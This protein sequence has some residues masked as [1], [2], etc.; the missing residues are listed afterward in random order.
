M[1]VNSRIHN[2][3]GVVK[4]SHVD[5]SLNANPIKPLGLKFTFTGTS[6]SDLMNL[7]KGYMIVRQK[8]IPTILTQGLAV[9]LS[10]KAKIPVLKNST[11]NI[12]ESFVKSEGS[13]VKLGN[14]FQIIP[15]TT[16]YI[17]T[18][19]LL[20]PEAN[21][22]SSL[23]QDYFN[24]SE[25]LLRSQKYKGLTYVG[26]NTNNPKVFD[27]ITLESNSPTTTIS[28]LTYVPKGTELI[29]DGVKSYSAK[30]GDAASSWKHADPINGDIEDISTSVQDTQVYKSFVKVRGEFNS[31]IGS[32]EN[33]TFGN[34]YNIMEKNY[35]VNSM[36]EYFKLRYN[37]KSS[38]SPISDRLEWSNSDV[39]P[40]LYRGDCYISTYTH[41]MMW[42]F[43]D[44]ELP[45]NTK[46]ID[47]YT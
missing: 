46:I 37:D 27:F 45:T 36:S 25:F 41:R 44:P 9:N 19:A 18:N 31:Y 33:L 4:L 47:P 13:K 23:F 29:S 2:S 15:N 17:S 6:K 7:T 1:V 32:S 28:K 22:R 30:A 10:A 24:S 8:R 39:T 3:K 26:Y 34:Y 21:L 5:W 40:N 38:Y 35:S 20:C 12:V 42:G 11:G 43:I 14:A 16:D